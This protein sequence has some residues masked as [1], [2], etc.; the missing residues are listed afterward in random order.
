MSTAAANDTGGRGR[1]ITQASVRYRPA[2]FVHGKAPAGCYHLSAQ[3]CVPLL[4]QRGLLGVHALLLCA[5]YHPPLHAFLNCGLS[6]DNIQ[7]TQ[8]SDAAIS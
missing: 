1:Y 6:Y 8:E 5:Y 4:R 7:V 3:F 2:R